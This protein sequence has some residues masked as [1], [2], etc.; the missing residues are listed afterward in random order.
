MKKPKSIAFSHGYSDK[1]TEPTN[2]LRDEILMLRQLLGYAPSSILPVARADPRLANSSLWD[3]VFVAVDIDTFQGYEGIIP[4]QQFHVG[5]SIL[6]TRRLQSMSCASR[7]QEQVGVPGESIQTDP[8][9][10][11]PID[12]AYCSL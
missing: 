4:D 5:V 1:K 2:I 9:A 10:V 8:S 3:A 7:R 12:I 6:D 11:L